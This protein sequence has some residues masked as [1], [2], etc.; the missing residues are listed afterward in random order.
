MPFGV[1]VTV[2][3]AF[4]LAIRTQ[5]TGTIISGVDV[6]W[7]KCISQIRSKF[8]MWFNMCPFSIEPNLL[9]VFQR[10][11]ID[12]VCGL[13]QLI[14]NTTTSVPEI[15]YPS[16]WSQCLRETDT[17][18]EP[19]TYLRGP[20]PQIL[21]FWGESKIRIILG[22]IICNLRKFQIQIYILPPSRNPTLETCLLSA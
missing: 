11:R 20:D 12:G 22:K 19:E 5:T 6:I 9:R 3:V 2:P 4:I 21:V 10:R 17:D 18:F 16:Y 13:Y 15:N 14:K 7:K 8:L 1:V